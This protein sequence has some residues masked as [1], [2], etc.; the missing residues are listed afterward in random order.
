L[1][2]TKTL[3]LIGQDAFTILPEEKKEAPKEDK[4]DK[5]KESENPK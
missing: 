3:A 5:S 2:D 1:F 4:P